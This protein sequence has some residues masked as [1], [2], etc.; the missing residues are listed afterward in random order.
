MQCATS[1]HA[2]RQVWRIAPRLATPGLNDEFDG[3][4][5]FCGLR[6]RFSSCYEGFGLYDHRIL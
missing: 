4:W 2:M 5:T 3:I 1:N 6:R